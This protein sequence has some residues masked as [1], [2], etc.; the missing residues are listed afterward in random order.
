MRF[1]TEYVHGKVKDNLE[2]GFISVNG[3]ETTQRSAAKTS[4]RQWKQRL[5]SFVG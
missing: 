4:K 5:T 3:E 2:K 1:F